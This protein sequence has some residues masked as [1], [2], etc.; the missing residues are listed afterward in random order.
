MDFLGNAGNRFHEKYDDFEIPRALS[1]A[2]RLKPHLALNSS[3]DATISFA[4]SIGVV[5]PAIMFHRF[6]LPH[7]VP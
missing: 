3:T 1:T 6:F 5:T 4:V 7:L 2:D